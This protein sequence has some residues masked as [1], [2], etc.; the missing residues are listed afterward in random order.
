MGRPTSL[1]EDTRERIGQL[2][3]AGMSI[4]DAAEYSRISRRSVYTWIERGEAEEFRIESGFDP[5]S[6]EE[7][8]L[9]FMHMV[10]QAIAYANVADMNVI[11]LA[12]QDNPFWAERRYK[13]RNPDL[14]RT[15]VDVAAK[16]EAVR[17]PH[18]LESLREVDYDEDTIRLIGELAERAAAQREIG[19]PA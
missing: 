11:G 10:R 18:P 2:I 6:E 16:V 3:R 5:D 4:K 15:K 17:P 1:T 14:F 12:A 13:L 9:E 19:G 8:Y 7:K